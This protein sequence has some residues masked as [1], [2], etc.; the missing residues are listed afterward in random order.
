MKTIFFAA[1]IV[2]LVGCGGGTFTLNQLENTKGKIPPGPLLDKMHEAIRVGN[3]TDVTERL[4]GIA[5]PAAERFDWAKFWSE[6]SMRDYREALIATHKKQLLDLHALDCESYP[7]FARFLLSVSSGTE[8]AVASERKCNT[9]I[10]PSVAIQIAKREE[11]IA[12]A[13]DRLDKLERTLK[14]LKL[15]ILGGQYSNAWISELQSSL[16]FVE[17]LGLEAARGGKFSTY[18]DVLVAGEKHGLMALPLNQLAAVVITTPANRE[19]WLSRFGF[20]EGTRRFHHHLGLSPNGMKALTPDQQDELNARLH[21]EIEATDPERLA[22]VYSTAA[23]LSRSVHAQETGTGR[24]IAAF[25]KLLLA[26]EAKWFSKDQA[27]R[28][29]KL[30]A[31]AKEVNGTA[32]S[33]ELVLFAGRTSAAHPLWPSHAVVQD[34]IDTIFS[35]SQN[36]ASTKTTVDK[37]A[38]KRALCDFLE[39]KDIGAKELTQQQ[40]ANQ[41]ADH[42]PAGC[43]LMGREPNAFRT[44]APKPLTASFASLIESNDTDFEMMAPAIRLG[45]I[46]LR[47]TEGPAKRLPTPTP[48]SANAV[49][50]PVLLGLEIPEKTVR[51]KKGS[52]AFIFHLTLKKAAA[53]AAEPQ[54]ALSGFDGPSLTLQVENPTRAPLFVSVPGAG[55]AESPARPGGQ[56]DKSTV[57][58]EQVNEW[59]DALSSLDKLEVLRPLT[60]HSEVDLNSLEEMLS[61]A[62]Q[63]PEKKIKVFTIP[64]YLHQLPAAEKAQ[65]I[66]AGEAHYGRRLKPEDLDDYYK[67]VLA[68]DAAQQLNSLLDQSTEN[69]LYSRTE[70]L[71]EFRAKDVYRVEG[72]ATGP[73]NLQGPEGK[74]GAIEVLVTKKP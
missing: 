22:T 21:R 39:A 60:V 8:Y 24:K 35:L 15:E 29:E 7:A 47:T 3:L 52:H 54:A 46:Y 73:R 66:A 48:P 34:E 74:P 67:T 41:L 69:G 10:E 53:G 33:H 58:F 37:M 9:R 45:A 2:T 30:T 28:D 26:A 40:L 27:F 14:F 18:L 65:V 19:Q 56:G 50:V 62:I 4:N 42:L 68:P 55:Q 13:P 17:K 72:G 61:T 57:D 31:S 43:Y 12:V 32:A 25:D 5:G 49:A 59:L 16:P 6:L 23:A 70:A 51:L 44:V 36:L 38:A 71:P 11:A 1:L 20:V 64:G 63:T